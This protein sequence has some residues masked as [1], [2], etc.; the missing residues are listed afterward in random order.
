MGFHREGESGHI[1]RESW[2]AWVHAN[3]DLLA[4]CGLPPGVLESR[5]DWQYLLRY[6]YWCEDFYGK[7]I[8]KIDFDLNQ[9]TPSQCDALRRLLERTLTAVEKRRGCAAWHHVHPP[10]D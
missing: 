2:D 8:G 5:R 6:G 3:S 1:E 7:H 10:T 4:H 9:L